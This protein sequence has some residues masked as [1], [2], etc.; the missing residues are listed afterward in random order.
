MYTPLYCIMCCNS[1]FSLHLLYMMCTVY[2]I[3]F[4]LILLY[5][6]N[7]KIGLKYIY[8]FHTGIF[9]GFKHFTPNYNKF[10][11]QY[12]FKDKHIFYQHI[13]WKT[14]SALLPGDVILFIIIFLLLPKSGPD[15]IISYTDI[16]FYI[17]YS[18]FV[19]Y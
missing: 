7:I 17:L 15:V 14:V 18:E 4:G 2:D 11:L 6:C 3:M 16:I 10:Q 8:R 12:F 1:F 5:I 19:L 13:S 9:F